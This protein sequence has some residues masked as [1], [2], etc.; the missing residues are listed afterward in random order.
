MADRAVS[1]ETS[2]EGIVDLINDDRWQARLEEARARREIALREKEKDPSAAPKRKLMPWE[3]EAK[4]ASVVD[5]VVQ[6][7]DSER[8]DFADRVDRVRENKSRDAGSAMAPPEPTAPARSSVS[9]PLPTSFEDLLAEEAFEEDEVNWAPPPKKPHSVIPEGA[10]DVIELASRYAST[11]TAPA[12]REDDVT[13]VFEEA[14]PAPVI[15]RSYSHPP[16]LL[17]VGVLFLAALPFAKTV[18]PLERGPAMPVTPSLRLEPALGFTTAMLWRPVETSSANW[19][20]ATSWSL[21]LATVY[22]PQTPSLEMRAATLAPLGLDQ[23]LVGLESSGAVDLAPR[24]AQPPILDGAAIDRLPGAFSRRPE[25]RPLEG[26]PVADVQAPSRAPDVASGN[27][28]SPKIAPATDPDATLLDQVNALKA[29]IFERAPDLAD[30]ALAAIRTP[31]PATPQSTGPER[32]LDLTILVPNKRD[33]EVAGQ[34]AQDAQARGHSIASIK[35][36]GV[37]IKTRNVRYFHSAD[38]SEAERL[39][40]EYGAQARSFTWF[41]PKPKPGT[42]ELWLEGDAAAPARTSRVTPAAPKATSAP[43]PTPAP[44]PKVVVLRKQEGF[45][46]RLLS[47]HRVGLGVAGADGASDSTQ[48]TIVPQAPEATGGTPSTGG[49]GTDGGTGATGTGSTG[50]GTGTTGETGAEGGTGTTTGGS[51]GGDT[52]TGTGA[53]TGTTR[54]SGGGATGSGTGGTGSTGSGA[55]TGGSTS[56]GTSGGTSGSGGTG[57]SNP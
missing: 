10:P 20:P 30:Q 48:S 56:G 16:A 13:D 32:V 28:P 54:G 19:S 29:V 41:E 51:T 53:G 8:V 46:S 31:T 17:I 40:A 33:A 3:K 57:S 1:D 6:A 50:A 55:G 23:E 42:V 39:A 18:P 45:L 11:L 43:T 44:T 21:P 7:P 52:S 14:K 34:F 22:S 27:E 12:A 26:E 24:S 2:A 5:P 37:N 35:S 38:R 36:V 47:G 9:A 49:T 4:K 15:A 25:P